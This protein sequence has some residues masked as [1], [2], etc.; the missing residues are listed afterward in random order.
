MKLPDLED[1]FQAADAHAEGA[2]D[3]DY[4]IGDLQEILR[5]AWA[6]MTPEQRA[7]VFARP[8]LVELAG[9]PE[10]EPLIGHLGTGR[11]SLHDS[12]L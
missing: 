10:F 7:A 4:A 8:E 2:G 1:L 11:E 9:L 12:S 6:I 3:F 5:A